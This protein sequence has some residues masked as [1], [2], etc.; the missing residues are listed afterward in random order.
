MTWKELQPC[1]L[2]LGT[3]QAA[4]QDKKG[5]G[6][7][8]LQPAGDS[9]KVKPKST[10][11]AAANHRNAQATDRQSPCHDNDE[12]ADLANEKG[13]QNVAPP[14]RVSTGECTGHSWLSL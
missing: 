8:K 9:G 12:E 14:T 7:R 5:K 13:R 2:P 4:A 1:L 3:A 6:K 10:A 11:D